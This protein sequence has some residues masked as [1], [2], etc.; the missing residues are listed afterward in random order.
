MHTVHSALSG[1]RVL[2]PS[3]CTD[4]VSEVV[5]RKCQ[6]DYSHSILVCDVLITAGLHTPL[7]LCD[8][9]VFPNSIRGV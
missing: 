9:T 3:N 4:G 8:T 1:K 7:Y 2:P 6:K 5:R